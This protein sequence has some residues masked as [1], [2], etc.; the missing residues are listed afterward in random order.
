MPQL[1]CSDRALE[2]G[3]G[4]MKFSSNLNYIDKDVSEVVQRRWLL[5]PLL[6]YDA[7]GATRPMNIASFNSLWPG[8]AEWR[9]RSGSTLAQVMAWRLFVAK[10]LSEPVMTYC[11]LHPWTNFN[12]IW[13][14]I[15]NCS[16]DKMDKK[17]RLRNGDIL[18]RQ[19]K[20]YVYSV[21]GQPRC[22]VLLGF[23]LLHPLLT[24]L[25]G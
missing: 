13:I 14:N 11:Q 2:F 1:S 15:Q 25:F 4:K 21:R 22:N 5:E 23:D 16:F 7:Y 24:T 10:P 20:V 17:C 12:E 9:H 19:A 6:V 8:D 3:G 18:P